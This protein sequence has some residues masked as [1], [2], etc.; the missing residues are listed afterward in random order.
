MAGQLPKMI[1]T[2]EQISSP[3]TA[4]PTGLCAASFITRAAPSTSARQ[5]ANS[6]QQL[7]CKE[8]FKAQG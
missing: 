1:P 5:K 7:G 2:T 8:H 6:Y 3:N 4:Q